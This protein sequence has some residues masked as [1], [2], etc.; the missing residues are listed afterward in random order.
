MRLI[1]SRTNPVIKQVAELTSARERTFQQLCIVEGVRT[2]TTL[3][4]SSRMKLHQLFVTEPMIAQA[5]TVAP[6][7]MIT[8]V[9]DSVM[10]KISQTSSSS[11]MLGVFHIPQP[12]SAL[13]GP[14]LVL[15]QVRDPGNVGTLIRTA[16][17]FGMKSIILIE[18]ADVWSP[19]VL[20]ATAGAVGSLDIFIM[21]WEELCMKVDKEKLC[22]LVVRGGKQAS[23]VKLAHSFLVVGNESQ[24]IPPTWLADCRQ[25]MTV[26]M[27]GEVE[28]LNAAVAGS[29]ALYEMGL[30]IKI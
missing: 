2:C 5:K 6:E 29:I 15:A 11:G 19:K 17:A 14:G 18:S 20:Q 10:E 16:A 23:E 24:G 9:A 27:P 4:N 22:A 28:S 8:E 7:H 26:A 25:K 1:T 30:S 3:L 13:T 21:S 12:T